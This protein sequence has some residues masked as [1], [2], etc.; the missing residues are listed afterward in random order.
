MKRWEA[1][2]YRTI[3][4]FEVEIRGISFRASMVDGIV[5]A[6]LMSFD[7]IGMDWMDEV[8]GAIHRKYPKA[9]RRVKKK[10]SPL[11]S[12]HAALSFVRLLLRRMRPEDIVP[13]NEAL[14][15]SEICKSCPL[16]KPIG[17]CPKCREALKLKIKVPIQIKGL[18]AC[19][20][21]GCHLPLKVWV[22]RDLL[23]PAEAF[24]YYPGCWM[25]EKV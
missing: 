4:P 22:N 8:Y 18:K 12:L 6:Y 21:C 15:R 1:T 16:H 20:A 10:G 13:A 14:R 23:G 24:P 17:A 2:H 25:R 7:D 5:R 11:P 19:A 3:Q 9:V